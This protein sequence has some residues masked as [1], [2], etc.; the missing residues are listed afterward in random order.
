[1]SFDEF[2]PHYLRQH[3]KAATRWWHFA[4]TTAV[5][6]TLGA[7]I[8]LRDARLL[9]ACLVLGYGPAWFSHFFIERNRPATFR[10]PL[11]SLAADFKM[12]GLMLVGRHDL[13][14]VPADEPEA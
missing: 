10:Y 4:G 14:T 7:A 3:R 9:A 8:A 13:V 11:L 12:W 5:L 2:W 6:G 1:M